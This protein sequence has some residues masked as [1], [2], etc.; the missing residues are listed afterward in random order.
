MLARTFHGLGVPRRCGASDDVCDRP[1]LR[2]DADRAQ[3]GLGGGPS[4]TESIRLPAG[5][6]SIGRGSDDERLGCDRGKAVDV[7][8]QVQLHDVALGEGLVGL[9]I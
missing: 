4:G 6:G 1:V 7:R 8:S 9:R 5:D 3:C 2:P